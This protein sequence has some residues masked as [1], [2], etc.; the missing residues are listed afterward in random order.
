MGIPMDM[1][2]SMVGI[3][4]GIEKRSHTHVKYGMIYC[5]YTH[6]SGQLYCWLLTYMTY[7]RKVE[8]SFINE[9]NSV[10]NVLCWIE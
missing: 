2:I 10:R 7:A 3:P 8:I 9:R 4:M 5:M 1:G 6:T